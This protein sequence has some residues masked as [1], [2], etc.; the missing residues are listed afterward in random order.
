MPQESLG[1][2]LPS[3]R[4]PALRWLAGATALLCGGAHAACGP[5]LTP[6]TGGRVLCDGV[7]TGSVSVTAAPGS[8]DVGITVGAGATLSTNATQALLVRDGSSIVNNGQITVSGGSGAARAAM[9]A[10]GDDNTLTNN[11]S[12]RTTSGGTAGLSTPSG[13]STR[14]QLSNTGSIVTTGGSSH[15]I[16]TFGPGNTVRNSGSIT[17]SGTAAKGV[18]LQGGNGVANV[19]INTGEIRALGANTSP[20]SGFADAVHANTV[21]A[22]TFF[23]RVENRAGGIISSASSYGYRGQNGNDVLVNAGFIEGHGGAD[24]DGALTMGPL[25]TGTLI[26]Q[27]GSVIRGAADGGA[28]RSDAFLDGSGTVDN[29]FRN[30]QTLTMRGDAWAWTTDASFSDSIRVQS[31]RFALAG[32]LA[33]PSI[34]VLPGAVVAGTGAFAGNVTNQGTLQPGPGA[35]NGYG[36]FTVRGNYVGSG[37]LLQVHT[38]LGSDASPTDR[39][40]IDGGTASGDT[41]VQVVNRGG[42][43]AATVADGIPL[44]QA[45]NGATTAPGAFALA[46]PVEAGAYSYRLFRGGPTGA[47]PESWFLRTNAFTVG[48]T[49]VGS[50]LEAAAVVA[51]AE[52]AN[53]GVSL[54]VDAVRL[55]RPEVALYSAIPI[56]VRRIGLAQVAT[57]NERRGDAAVSAGDDAAPASWGRVFG[58]RTK[59][60]LGGDANPEFDGSIGGLQVGHD[61]VSRRSD[62]GTRDRAGLMAGTVRGQGDASGMADGALDTKVGRLDLEGYSLGA[63][64]TRV[65]ASGAYADAVLLATR[66]KVDALSTR[67][68]GGK[69]HGNLLTASLEGGIPLPIGDAVVLEPQ[70]QLIWQRSTLD[71]LDDTV[72]AVRFD[73]DHATTARLGLRL[74]GSDATAAWQPFLK[75]NLWHTFGGSSGAVFGI[76]DTV[77][78]ERQASALEVGVGVTGRINDRVAVYAGLASTRALGTTRLHSVQGQLGMQ[79]RW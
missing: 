22:S 73:D 62:T 42:V 76:A 57:F 38:V 27:T 72:S 37:A 71:A 41:R 17:V 32:T 40:V 50:A 51:A 46:Q 60:G 55:Y 39:L 1:P 66:Y 8:T 16:F 19:L 65:G 67:G 24:G 44:V 23:S 79:L 29:A 14:S 4:L 2:R 6:G 35:G 31:G 9:A 68:R 13:S 10:T 47:S 20:T 74:H 58:Q 63:Y 69:P 33:S 53:P 26:L 56:V 61:L 54:S 18:Y 5:T 21:G 75:L 3:V 45:V 7:T 28:A 48:D 11:G 64:W 49:V 78:T 12:I 70:A 15:G 52:A 34:A 25:G 43:G 59:Q 77:S 36:A 30:F